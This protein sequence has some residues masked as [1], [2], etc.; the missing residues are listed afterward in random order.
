M[1]KQEFRKVKL[2]TNYTLV[3]R[4]IDRSPLLF[5]TELSMDHPCRNMTRANNEIIFFMFLLH[6]F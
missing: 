6:Q 1:K 4:N 5:T 2:C 3:F